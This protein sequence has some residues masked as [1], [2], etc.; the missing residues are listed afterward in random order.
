MNL[1]PNQPL[2]CYNHPTVQT[3]L[4]CNRCNRPICTKCAVLTPTGYRCKECV[5]GQQKTFETAQSTD[6]IFAVVIAGVLGFVGSLVASILGFFVI[7]IGPIAGLIVAE[8]VRA[9]VH[10]RRSK[11]LFQAAAAAA[12]IGSLPLVLQRVLIILLVGA[13]GGLGGSLASLLPLLWQGLFTF[14]LTSSVYYRLAG[15]Q[16]K[17]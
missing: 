4:R 9:V 15:I 6:F 10:K 7:F 17:Y 16:M 14:M 1:D 8:A 2:Y 13:N 11:R 3:N 12:A 5:R